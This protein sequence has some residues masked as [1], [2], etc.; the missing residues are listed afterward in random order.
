[1]QFW[2]ELAAEM[3]REWFAANKQRYE[4][5][6]VEPITALLEGVARELA[7]AYRP[8]KLGQPKALRIYRDVRFSADKT[9]YRPTSPR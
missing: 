8:L 2:H 3:S 9:P 6:W 5:V 1:M 4:T 7:P